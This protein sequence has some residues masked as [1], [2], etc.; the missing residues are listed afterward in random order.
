MT[1]S[2]CGPSDPVRVGILG[3]GY[4]GS[5]HARVLAATVGVGEFSFDRL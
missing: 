3:C 5:K 1:S 2:Q 4:W